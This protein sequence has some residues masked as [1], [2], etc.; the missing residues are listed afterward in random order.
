MRSHVGALMLPSCPTG[1]ASL[2]RAWLAPGP[3]QLQAL[4]CPARNPD[5]DGDTQGYGRQSGAVFPDIILV[6][7]PNSLVSL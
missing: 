6:L 5:A 4:A 7:S 2:G 3:G 1:V